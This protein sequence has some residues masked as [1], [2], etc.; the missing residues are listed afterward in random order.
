[1]YFLLL[2]TEVVL[3]GKK[4]QILMQVPKIFS[5]LKLPH[6]SFRFVLFGSEIIQTMYELS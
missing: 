6:D 3:L 5:I 1:M 4:F 2:P